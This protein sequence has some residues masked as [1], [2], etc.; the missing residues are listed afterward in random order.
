MWIRG[1]DL[2]GLGQGQLADCCGYGSRL[3]P[4]LCGGNGHV[5]SIH[6]VHYKIPNV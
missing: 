6:V 1:L 4:L 5:M 3:A 2:P